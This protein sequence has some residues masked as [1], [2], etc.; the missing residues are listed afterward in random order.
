[1]AL[2]NAIGF[3]RRIISCNTMNATKLVGGFP[4]YTVVEAN[5]LDERLIEGSMAWVSDE[6][7]GP[8][9]ARS[10]GADWIVPLTG[11]PIA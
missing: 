2:R 11:A 7:G 10:D 8:V 1:M 9:L 4:S 3:F 6:T 5:A